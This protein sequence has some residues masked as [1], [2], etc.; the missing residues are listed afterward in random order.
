MGANGIQE[1][2]MIVHDKCNMTPEKFVAATSTNAAKVYGLYPDKGRIDV[3]SQADIVIWNPEV[4]THI[5]CNTNENENYDQISK[6]DLNIFQGMSFKGKAE[7]VILRGRVVLFEGD[8]KVVHGHGRFLPLSPYPA[9]V[10]E[11][12]KARE[13]QMF[14]LHPVERKEN[15]E[16]KINGND[17]PPPASPISFQPEKAASLHISNID[18]K[19]H[20][21]DEDPLQEPVVH[22]LAR[23]KHRSSIRIRNPPGGQTSGSFW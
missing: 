12:I 18:L 17:I 3:G 11:K 19:L 6:S 9:H 21:N 5:T 14:N 15:E 1:R 10:Y 8:L 2:M 7:T 16:I 20:P 23:N 4:T 22:V 13:Q